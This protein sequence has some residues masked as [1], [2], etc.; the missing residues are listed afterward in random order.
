MEERGIAKAGWAH[1]LTRAIDVEGCSVTHH[2]DRFLDLIFL[3]FGLSQVALRFRVIYCR[4][5]HPSQELVHSIR[6]L[7]WLLTR[8]LAVSVLL[9]RHWSSH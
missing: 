3:E 6:C 7:L 8:L 1:Q 9:Y 2:A 5:G 4:R